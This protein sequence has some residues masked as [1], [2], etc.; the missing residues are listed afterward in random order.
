M[1]RFYATGTTVTLMPQSTNPEHQ[2]QIYDTAKTKIRVIGKVVKVE[3][4][5]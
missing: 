3:F 2:P 5:L 4:T 1:K